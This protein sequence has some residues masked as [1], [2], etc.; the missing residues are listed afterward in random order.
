MKNSL[1]ILFLCLTGI[2]FSQKNE[3]FY[4]TSTG[5]FVFKF[6]G[7]D[8]ILYR[9]SKYDN[10][11][12]REMEMHPTHRAKSQLDSLGV[13]FSNGQY[14]I[15]YDYKDFR[16]CS[17]KKGR[18]KDNRA[19]VA[20]KLDDPSKVYEAINHRYW[21]EASKKTLDEINNDYPLFNGYY[22]RYDTSSWD[23]I[24][25][26][27][28]VPEEFE[29]RAN[30]QIEGLKDSLDNLNCKLIAL[31]DTIEMYMEI[32]TL[33]ELKRN[34]LNRPLD[35]YAYDQYQ[36]EMLESVALNRPDLF[37]ELAE[38]LPNEK[39]AI[40]YSVSYSRD[41]KKSLKSVPDSP[42]KKEFSKYRRK[43]KW[44]FGLIVSAAITIETA[45]IGGIIT[46]I[47]YLIVR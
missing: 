14:A 30:H 12:Y 11:A 42:I 47:V 8:C 16:L 2:S 21:Y 5:E 13:L 39:D 9:I 20:K 29:Q 35:S 34:Y 15:S 38:A 41:V 1:V 23:S 43:E 10:M 6:E 24:S 37:F 36:D 40:F 31:N 26:Q 32:L 27:Q 18:V 28:V 45:I 33:E 4:Q 7:E 46:G 44:K 17:L 22:H 3:T 19:Y 25:F